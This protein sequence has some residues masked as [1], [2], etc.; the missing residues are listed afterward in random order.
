[1]SI[2]SSPSSGQF[3]PDSEHSHRRTVLSCSLYVL[4]TSLYW[5]Q[6]HRDEDQAWVEAGGLLDRLRADS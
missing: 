5:W 2:L 1:M 6:V 4:Y 3:R